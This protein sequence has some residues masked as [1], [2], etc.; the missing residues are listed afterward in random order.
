MLLEVTDLSI[1]LIPR[2][3]RFALYHRNS[4]S[5]T[6]KKKQKKKQK[7]KSEILNRRDVY[8]SL[9]HADIYLPRV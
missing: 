4:D 9:F 6:A 5:R 2:F 3:N 1:I 7:T 8:F